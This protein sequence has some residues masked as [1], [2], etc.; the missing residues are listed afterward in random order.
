MKALVVR[1]K[2][3]GN[4]LALLLLTF[5]A[6][7]G[8]SG[9][10]IAISAPAGAPQTLLLEHRATEMLSQVDVIFEFRDSDGNAVSSESQTLTSWQPRTQVE[11]ARP[12]RPVARLV[13][14][15]KP[16]GATTF[17]DSLLGRGTVRFV[18]DNLP[19]PDSGREIMAQPAA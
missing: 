1:A 2:V 9:Y 6:C 3:R 13:V 8:P 4:L 16:S 18:V 7:G 10:A 19:S 12:A 14:R 17:L 5:A 11:F 15:I